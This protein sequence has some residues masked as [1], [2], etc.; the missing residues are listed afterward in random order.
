MNYLV[1]IE[2]KAIKVGETIRDFRNKEWKFLGTTRAGS[3]IYAEDTEIK[4]GRPWRQE[5]FPSVFK[6]TIEEVN[7]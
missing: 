7:D 6:A 2:G 3:R 4:D 5:F 1:R